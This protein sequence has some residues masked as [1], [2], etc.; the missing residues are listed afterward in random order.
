[1]DLKPKLLEVFFEVQ[2][3]LPRQGPGSNES[4]I[5]A[6]ELCRE[7]PDN[8]AV[9][10]IGCGPG[11]QTMALAGTA[12]PDAGAAFERD[13]KER[14]EHHLVVE[15]LRRRLAAFGAVREGE[16][17]ILDVGGM[18]HFLTRFEVALEKQPAVDE[19]ISALHP[20]PAVGVVPR[21]Q[22]ALSMLHS[23]RE[24]LGVPDAFGAP[25]GVKLG[26][27][28]EAS[29]AIRGLFWQGGRVLLPSGCGIVG[30]SKLGDEWA[31][32]GLKRRWVKNAFGLA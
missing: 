23:I 30:A 14:V 22:L 21:S 16:R 5:K 19:V 7:L 11:M 8:P 15:A 1:M 26:E 18:I 6:L 12:E 3:G 27:H 24:N 25:F 29:V 10:D 28:F 9:L 32:L 13:D 2:R 17:E 20:T 4:T 31:E